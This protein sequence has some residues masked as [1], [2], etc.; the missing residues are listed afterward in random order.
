MAAKQELDPRRELDTGVYMDAP[1]LRAEFHAYASGKSGIHAVPLD[2]A[3]RIYQDRCAPGVSNG[4]DEIIWI[5]IVSPGRAEAEFL[6]ETMGFHPLAVEDCIR[7]RQRP[8]VDRYNGYFFLVMYAARINTERNR[9]ALNEIHIF[10]GERFVV[11]VHD[12]RVGEI[13]EVVARWR[14]TPGEYKDTGALAH[15][16]LDIIV[17][18]YFPVL[19]DF[20]ER[21]DEL[22]D[23]MFDATEE[24]RMH[25]VLDL[26]RQLTIFR[27]VVAPERDLFTTLLRRDLPFLRPELLP[28][29]QDVHDHVMRLTEEIDLLR[30]LLSASVEGYLSATSNRLN[31]TMRVMAA[32]SIILMAVTLV[33]GIYGMNFRI[34]PELQWRY[35]YAWALTA[36][37]VIG[38]VLVVYFKRR[39]WL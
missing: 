12:H 20:S 10:L 7:G 31:Q 30:E 18:D 32:W 28:Y 4:N 2:E 33:A 5:D 21:V 16:L 36:M 6:R 26:R 22:E 37:G 34:M 35:G 24:D 23:M 27:R 9:M 25:T 39:R 19:D 3:I 17:D 1:E 13:G 15:T 38:G 14:A 8:K 29:F 11:T